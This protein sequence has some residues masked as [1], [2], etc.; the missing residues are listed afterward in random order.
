MIINKEEIIVSTYGP[1]SKN[2]VPDAAKFGGASV[3]AAEPGKGTQPAPA[4]D[5]ATA[6]RRAIALDPKM[7]DQR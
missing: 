3:P 7:R 4:V 2:A 5:Q 1:A 6:A